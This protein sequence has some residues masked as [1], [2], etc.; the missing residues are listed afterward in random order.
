MFKKLSMGI[1]GIALLAGVTACG[2]IN[3]GADKIGLNVDFTNVYEHADSFTENSYVT[4]RLYEATLDAA[5]FACDVDVNPVAVETPIEVCEKA[6]DAAQKL[7]P[8]VQAASRSIGTYVYLD[9]KVD[10]IREDGEVVP[11][12][13]L[14]AASEAFF[15]ARGEW[16][17]IEGDIRAYIGG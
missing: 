15:K 8:A 9:N 12:E 2:T 17:A 1:A 16:A 3:D 10:Q 4:I 6:A 11:D 7:S 13:I 5:I 14:Q